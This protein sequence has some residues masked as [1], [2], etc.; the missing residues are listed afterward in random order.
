MDMSQYLEIFID[1]SK[2]HLQTINEQ[3]LELEKTPED[4]TIVNEI[5]RSAHTLKGMSATMGFEDLANLTHQMENVLDGI[6]NHKITVTSEILDVV[7][8]AVDHLEAMIMSIAEGGDGKRDVKEVVERLKRIERGELPAELAAAT[9]AESPSSSASFSQTYGEFEYNVLQQ[10]K[11]QGFSAYEIR[12]KLRDDCLLKAARVF[13]VFEAL[14]EMGEVIKSNPSVEMLEEE[15]FDQEFVVTVVSKKSAEELYERIMKVSEIEEVDVVPF[16]VEERKKTDAAEAAQAEARQ[17][18]AATVQAKQQKQTKDSSEPNVA[19]KQSAS[20]NK[21]I[22]VN[23]ERLD[24]LM[25][26]FEELVIDRGRLE[27]ISR[28]LNHPEL[29][30]TVERMSRISSDLQNIILNMRMVPVETV[31]NRFPRMVRQLARELG[32]K[33]NLE[34]IGAETELDRT[35]IDEI[36]D[37]LVHLLRNAIDHGIETP[38]VRRASGKPEEG[39]VKLKAYHSGNHVFIEI[40]DDGAGINR[41][42]VL[43]KAIDKGIVSKQNAENLTDRQIYE[44]IFA[45]GFSTADKISD[46]SGRGVGLDVVKSTI[47]SLGG[48]VT[49]DSE[50]GSGSIFSI[51]LPLTL[52]II[53]VLLVEIQQEKYAIPLSSIIE[54]AI[55]KKEDIF[56]T[57]N[58][59]VIDFRGKVVPLVFLK[60][61]FEIPTV[62]EEEEFVSVVIVRKGEKMA[63][64]VVDSFIGQQEVVLKSLGNYL[65]SVFAISGATILGDGQVA[66][67]IDCNSLIK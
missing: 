33:V 17:Q 26:L 46:I 29:H 56:H 58:Q 25:N 6:R 51:Q 50:E 35:V 41:D 49:V 32:K 60:E 57:H 64:L 23:I 31:F 9:A 4:M 27:Q 8:Q 16:D 45:P 38:D 48:T 36:G 28:E 2:E 22:R 13:M 65:T 7:F 15:Q 37:P 21:T 66:L 12:V 18:E 61:I 5:F 24:I 19:A 44:L 10:S 30:E 42:K 52:S 40:E 62:T 53:S 43:R 55:I 54:T 34:I 3:L 1:E 67:I 14:N 11:E 47:E 20:T 63:G 39:T 59:Q